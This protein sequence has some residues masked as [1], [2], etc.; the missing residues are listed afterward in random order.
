MDDS[1]LFAEIFVYLL[2]WNDSDPKA[3]NVIL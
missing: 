1:S 2:I 3:E